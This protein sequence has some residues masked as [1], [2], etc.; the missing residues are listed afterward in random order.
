MSKLLASLFGNPKKKVPVVKGYKGSA[1]EAF[2][3]G[4]LNT[5]KL[6][7]ILLAIIG[8]WLVFFDRLG[9]SREAM[10]LLTEKETKC[11]ADNF[12]DF[13]KEDG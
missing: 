6:V 1:E 13:V 4:T 9:M 7:S 11:L 12:P 5:V 2:M 10:A 3:D 8:K